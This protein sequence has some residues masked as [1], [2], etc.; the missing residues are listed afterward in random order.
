MENRNLLRKMLQSGGAIFAGIAV[1]IVLSLGTDMLLRAAGVMPPLGEQVAGSL[2]GVATVYRTAY[3]VIGSY[4][5][6][7]VAAERP[8][9]H[10]L[11][12]GF[13]GLWANV[14]GTVATW[15]KGPEFGPHWYPI[16]LIL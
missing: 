15:N 7:L 2:L 1:G 14:A 8:M 4:V 13:L 6:A 9:L 3:G 12:L 5:T 10:S 16:A 11:V